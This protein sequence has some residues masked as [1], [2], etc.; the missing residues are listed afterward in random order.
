MSFLTRLN[1][2]MEE[3]GNGLGTR[4][5]N[6]DRGGRSGKVEGRFPPPHASSLSSRYFRE[7]TP[8]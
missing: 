4:T 1:G 2:K 3:K 8:Q 7:R 6:G 5:R